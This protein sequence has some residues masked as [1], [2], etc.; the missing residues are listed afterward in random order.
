[1][2]E[3]QYSVYRGKD[4]TLFIV[5]PEKIVVQ[6]TLQEFYLVPQEYDAGDRIDMI[7][8]FIH[9]GIVN[10]LPSLRRRIKGYFTLEA[11]Y[12]RH[13]LLEKV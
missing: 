3:L 1:M 12:N 8:F 4:N 10:D 13:K 9:R 6:T 7:G 2:I 5:S 11:T